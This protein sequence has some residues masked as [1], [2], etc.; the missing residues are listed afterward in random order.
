MATIKSLLADA[1]DSHL[2]S[3]KK[4]VGKQGFP[5]KDII[6]TI[7]FRPLDETLLGICYSN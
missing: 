7:P 3:E 6:T 1:L 2:K 5:H 4:W